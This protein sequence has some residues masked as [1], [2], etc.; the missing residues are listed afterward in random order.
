MEE[1]VLGNSYVQWIQ[2][3]RSFLLIFLFVRVVVFRGKNN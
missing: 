2:S 1:V 3:W